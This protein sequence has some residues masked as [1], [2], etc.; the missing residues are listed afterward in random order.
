MCC[1]RGLRYQHPLCTAHDSTMHYMQLSAGLVG[2]GWTGVCGGL[3][4]SIAAKCGP[5]FPRPPISPHRV[6][7]QPIPFIVGMLIPYHESKSPGA[8][9]GTPQRVNRNTCSAGRGTQYKSTT[10]TRIDCA[11]THE[12]GQFVAIPH[13][14]SQ[15]TPSSS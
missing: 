11:A 1:C 7:L 3:S 13:Q 9:D 6:S 4:R 15:S 10:T 12:T 14:S 8:A 2:A 5:T